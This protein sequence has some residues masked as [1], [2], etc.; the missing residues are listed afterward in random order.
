MRT[1]GAAQAAADPAAS[2]LG[3]AGAY[4]PANGYDYYNRRPAAA[5]PERAGAAD[6]GAAGVGQD[7]YS[8]PRAGAGAGAYDRAGAGAMGG[9]GAGG[10]GMPQQQTQQA[11]PYDS[12]SAL[13]TQPI[14][15]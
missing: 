12:Q 4:P 13:Q 3:S 10:Y 11:K 1:P 14:F 15:F 7:F 8:A 6:Y 9:A 2:R 5:A